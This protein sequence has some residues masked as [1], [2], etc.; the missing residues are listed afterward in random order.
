[1]YT[2]ISENSQ[3]IY[4]ILIELFNQQ[5]IAATYLPVIGL[6]FQFAGRDVLSLVHDYIINTL[7][8]FLQKKN[9]CN[10]TVSST[11][12][13]TGSVSRDNDQAKEYF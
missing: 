7:M 2:Y 4:I 5:I 8:P 10:Q 3:V 13:R 1:M 9:A 11:S 12:L 6:M